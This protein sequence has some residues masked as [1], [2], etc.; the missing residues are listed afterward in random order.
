MERLRKFSIQSVLQTKNRPEYVG[1]ANTHDN[2]S[3]N[4]FKLRVQYAEMA[5]DLLQRVKNTPWI[6]ARH[7]FSSE[8]CIFEL[9]I[10]LSEIEGLRPIEYLAKFL[11]IKSRRKRLFELVSLIDNKLL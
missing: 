2:F 10:D 1:W 6:A 3:E 7:G 5:R 8:M 4:F 9:P 11:K